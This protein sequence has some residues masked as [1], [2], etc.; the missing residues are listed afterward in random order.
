MPEVDINYWAVLVAGIASM[1][2]G[3]LMY[4]PV[5]GNK[6]MELMGKTKEEIEK[7]G[8]AGKAM[9]L[10]FV[11]ALVGS[12]VLAHFVDYLGAETWWDGVVAAAWL[13]LGFVFISHVT[14]NLFE[15]RKWGLVWIFLL[16]TLIT[17]AVQGAILAAWV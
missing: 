3:A 8:N 13:W 1:V 10:A 16:N 11:A 15:S 2:V 12:F 5:L 6:W 14:N 7:E 4:G 9:G 17:M